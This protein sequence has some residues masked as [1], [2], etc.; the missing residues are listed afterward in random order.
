MG[1]NDWFNVSIKPGNTN[2]GYLCYKK[3]EK[4]PFSMDSLLFSFD[5]TLEFDKLVKQ[6]SETPMPEPAKPAVTKPNTIATGTIFKYKR[7]AVDNINGRIFKRGFDDNN[8]MVATY[9]EY[10]DED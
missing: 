6:E 5:G 10:T 9:E 2:T 3:A 4:K 7:V 1:S 8:R